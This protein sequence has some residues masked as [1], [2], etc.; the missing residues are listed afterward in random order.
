MPFPPVHIVSQTEYFVSGD[1]SIHETAMVAPGVILQAAVNSQIRVAAGVCI[2][3]GT[4][5]NAYAGIISIESGATL[6]PG[7]LMIGR[8]SV[9]EGACVGTKT[10]IINGSIE[11]FTMIAAGSLLGDSSRSWEAEAQS[12]TDKYL[13]QET[14]SVGDSL[15]SPWDTEEEVKKSAKPTAIRSSEK[16]DMSKEMVEEGVKKKEIVKTE[17]VAEM[18]IFTEPRQP[19]VGQVYI[20]Q[21]IVTLFPERRNFKNS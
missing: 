16:V 20:N 11:A 6:G 17:V 7:V 5:L 3:M 4:I 15:P 9:G 1:V 12:V 19:V 18:P 13:E 21:L 2:G 14:K 8:C 10:T